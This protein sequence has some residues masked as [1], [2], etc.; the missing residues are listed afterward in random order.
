M[1]RTVALL[2][3]AAAAIAAVAAADGTFAV[4]GFDGLVDGC[5]RVSV[6]N[7]WHDYV[8]DSKSAE[9]LKSELPSSVIVC[10]GSFEHAVVLGASESEC[11]IDHSAIFVDGACAHKVVTAARRTSTRTLVDACTANIYTAG[12]GVHTVNTL[13]QELVT[14]CTGQRYGRV[15][16]VIG[17][18]DTLQSS[19]CGYSNP[20]TRQVLLNGFDQVGC[21]VGSCLINVDDSCGLQQEITFATVLG[22]EYFI[23]LTGYSSGSVSANQ[24]IQFDISIAPT[25]DCPDV[26]PTESLPAA[27]PTPTPT[28]GGFNPTFCSG[29]T[30]FGATVAV[31]TTGADVLLIRSIPAGS[32]IT[33][34]YSQRQSGSCLFAEPTCSS[35][36]CI[37]DSGVEVRIDVRTEII[38]LAY[39]DAISIEADPIA[40][41]AVLFPYEFEGTTYDLCFEN[42]FPDEAFPDGFDEDAEDQC[43]RPV[44]IVFLLDSSGSVSTSDFELGRQFVVDVVDATGIWATGPNAG[45]AQFDDTAQEESPVTGNYGDFLASTITMNKNGGG[46]DF[47]NAFQLARTMLEATSRPLTSATIVL[48]TDGVANDPSSVTNPLKA[49]GVTII[50][51]GVGPGV[52]VA[53]ITAIASDP[54]L[55][56][57]SP[58]FSALTAL[59]DAVSG[60]TVCDDDNACTRDICNADGSCTFEIDLTRV[61]QVD[62]PYKAPCAFA[63]EGWECIT[64]AIDE[65]SRCVTVDG[66]PCAACPDNFG[67]D[68]LGDCRTSCTYCRHCAPG[69]YCSAGAECVPRRA[70]CAGCAYDTQ[71]LSDVCLDGVCTSPAAPL[72]APTC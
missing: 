9:D 18:G 62:C 31:N 70:M 37:V 49:D 14:P 45:L 60:T 72:E 47:I 29:T 7:G 44:D 40:T 56:F 35:G 50:S 15:I 30:S 32:P 27:L 1:M 43:R 69:H 34:Q 57:T 26:R 61:G 68:W 33:V 67:F 16:R 36:Q 8:C 13:D 19:T 46:T 10:G 52:N 3:A 66:S 64:G 2:L 5:E 28:P 21:G 55:V 39:N 11:A 25:D 24:D 54:S 59:V 20:D 71:C 42:P 22:Q 58:S 53:A 6:S 23:W 38:Y 65:N 4:H 48:I 12:L 41:P 17:T 51:V 63:F